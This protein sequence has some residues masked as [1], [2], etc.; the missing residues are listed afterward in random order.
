MPPRA[1]PHRTAQA[2]RSARSDPDTVGVPGSDK[3]G[4][5]WLIRICQKLPQAD[6][7]RVGAEKDGTQQDS[8]VSGLKTQVHGGATC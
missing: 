2:S 7:L 8:Q 5:P 3:Q 6:S 1:P 4:V